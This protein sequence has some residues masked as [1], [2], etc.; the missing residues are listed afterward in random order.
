[1]G[2]VYGA[3]FFKKNLSLV[4]KGKERKEA[5]SGRGKKRGRGEREQEEEKRGG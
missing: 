1:V 4:V 2:I 3:V 5:T